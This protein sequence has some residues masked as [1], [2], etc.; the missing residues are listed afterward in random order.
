MCVARRF[1]FQDRLID[2]LSYMKTGIITFHR[3]FNFG[4]VLQAYALQRTLE[5]LG[6]TTEIVDYG[7][8]GEGSRFPNVRLT[9][10]SVI[11][12]I[13]CLLCTAGADDLKRK[14]YRQFRKQYLVVSKSRYRDS[15]ALKDA[16]Y[17]CYVVGSDQ[18]WNPVFSKAHPGY[19]LD[20]TEGRVISKKIAYAPSFG[21]SELPDEWVDYYR[22][23]LFKFDY[24]SC[25]EDEG[26]RIIKKL[27]GRSC[28]VLLDP[29]LLLTCH[30]YDKI[31]KESGKKTKYICCYTVGA[32]RWTSVIAKKIAKKR[33]L[34]IKY[35]CSGARAS[36]FGNQK[37]S[38]AGPSE[39]LGIVKNASLVV[40][41]SFHGSVF[42]V[43][44][45]R[46]F[47][48]CKN[49]TE[50][51]SRLLTFLTT[52]GLVDRLIDPQNTCDE[53]FQ[54]RPIN[55]SLCNVLLSIEREKSLSYLQEAL[56]IAK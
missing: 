27:L 51:D 12:F 9:L 56:G 45:Q 22:S 46:P 42:S 28:P 15:E 4:A 17:A 20:F 31:A 50:G 48:V 53:D 35:L 36:W 44:Y 55:Y 33:G 29:T 54:E 39:F 7:S 26:Q 6:F 11:S 47:F 41:N 40:T 3:A 14:R 19:F 1:I 38:S 2:K 18:V 13:K 23:C 25:R 10:K 37:F 21:L 43:I 52:I 16:D 5:R 32:S 8:V 34:R 30:D 49:G 24:I